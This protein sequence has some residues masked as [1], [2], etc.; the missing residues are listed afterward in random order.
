MRAYVRACMRARVCV[1][2]LQKQP[3]PWPEFSKIH[4][5]ALV[6]LIK[7][8]QASVCSRHYI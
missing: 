5:D 2:R 4:H 7:V 8:T 1:A 3:F 6:M